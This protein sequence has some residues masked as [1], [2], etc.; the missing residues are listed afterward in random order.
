MS[1]C[2]RTVTVSLLLAVVASPASGTAVTVYVRRPGAVGV[3][4]RSAVASPPSAGSAMGAEPT[5][6]PPSATVTVVCCPPKPTARTPA[7]IGNGVPTVATSFV[8][9]RARR[10]SRPETLSPTT[11]V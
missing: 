9:T 6:R 5:F 8:A 2:T 7:W 11:A 1:D 10:T 4:T 3:T